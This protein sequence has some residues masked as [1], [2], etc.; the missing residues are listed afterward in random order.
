MLTTDFVEN[1]LHANQ[2]LISQPHCSRDNSEKI[3][4]LTIFYECLEVKKSKNA[5]N[6]MTK[7]NLRLLQMA[8][9]FSHTGFVI[10]LLVRQ[11]VVVLI[12]SVFAESNDI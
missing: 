8:L 1:Q 4:K 2:S 11:M 9:L 5:T 6:N 3:H 7:G 12:I 10:F